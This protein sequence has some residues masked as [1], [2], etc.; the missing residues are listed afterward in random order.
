MSDETRRSTPAPLTLPDAAD[1]EWLRKQAKRH[2]TE[3]RR[4][5][6]GARLAD[7]QFTLATQYGFS[8]W[9]AL[10][11]HVDATTLEGQLVDA[12][13]QGDVSKLAVLLDNTRTHFISGRSRTSGRCCITPRATV[14]CRR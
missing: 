13:R 12:A 9:R 4:A 8:S 6:P 14:I 3:L 7:A 2:L 10:K 1:L 5:N 11:V